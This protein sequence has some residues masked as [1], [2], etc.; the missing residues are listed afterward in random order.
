[1]V[2]VT[3]EKTVDKVQVSRSAGTCTDGEFARELRFSAPAAKA[4]T[5]SWRV[6]IHSMVFI[7]L[8]LSLSPFSESPVTP[9]IRFTPACSRVFAMYAATVCFMVV[10]L[11]YVISLTSLEESHCIGCLVF[12][13]HRQ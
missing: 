6:G 11:L 4:A 5:S 12:H 10:L 7:L 13:T 3:V 8:R 9:Q 1:M 2:A